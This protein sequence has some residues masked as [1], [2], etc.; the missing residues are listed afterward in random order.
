MRAA[1]ETW[2]EHVSPGSLRDDL[3]RVRR[4]LRLGAEPIA[5]LSPLAASLTDDVRT[6]QAVVALVTRTGGDASAMVVGLARAIEA[7][8]ASASSARAAA[9]GARLSGR[10]IAA[11]PLGFLPLAPIADAPL[12]DPAGILLLVSGGGLCLAGMTW[13]GRL[14]PVPPEDDPAAFLA[15]LVAAVVRGGVALASALDAV[16]EAGASGAT[17]DLERCRRLVRLGLPWPR[18]LRHCDHAGLRGL[19]SVLETAHAFGLPVGANLE[20]WARQRRA[21]VERGF[22][23]ATRRAGVLMMVPLA[24]CVLPSFILLAVAPFLR[25]LAS[26]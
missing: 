9:S 24:T 8:A 11:L 7:R 6:L 15:D 5:A 14:M 19:A 17:E 23:S 25:G 16:A 26:S 1:L 10:L 12:L 13:I 3:L 18:A 2:P 4:R 20:A 22:E 21:E